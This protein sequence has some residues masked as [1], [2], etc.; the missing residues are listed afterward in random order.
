MSI[1]KISCLRT[2]LIVTLPMPDA[3]LSAKTP[4]WYAPLSLQITNFSDCFCLNSD[5]RSGYLRCCEKL[6]NRIQ[7]AIKPINT[8]LSGKAS[9]DLPIDRRG[10]SRSRYAYSGRVPRRS[11]QSHSNRV[12]LLADFHSRLVRMQGYM[13][14]ATAREDV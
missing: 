7:N 10:V 12:R 5:R 9:L 13:V 1:L 2:P 14:S 8:R 11:W 6:L 3:F 4:T